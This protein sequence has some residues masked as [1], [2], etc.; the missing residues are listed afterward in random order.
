MEWKR[1]HAFVAEIRRFLRRFRIVEMKTEVFAEMHE[2]ETP[3]CGTRYEPTGR[4][5]VVI[6]LTGYWRQK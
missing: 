2:T 6:K 1:K 3:T 5:V 4:D